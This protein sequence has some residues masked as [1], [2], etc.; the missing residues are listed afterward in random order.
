MAKERIF[1]DALCLNITP[2]MRARLNRFI[3]ERCGQYAKPAPVVRDLINMALAY[4]GYASPEQQP[5]PQAAPFPPPPMSPF[6][7]INGAPQHGR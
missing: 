3:A 7:P 4:Y 5:Q 6:A 2:E 1:S